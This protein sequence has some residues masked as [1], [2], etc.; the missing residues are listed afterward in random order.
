MLLKDVDRL[1]KLVSGVRELA[2]I[3]TQLSTGE[4]PV[5]NLSEML[6]VLVTGRGL[7]VSTRLKLQLPAAPILVLGSSDRLWQ[8]FENLIDN[9]AGFSPSG[10]VVEIGAAVQSGECVVTVADRGPGIPEAHLARVFD[11]FFSYRPGGDRR[12]HMGLGLAIAQA[13]VS[14]YGGAIAVRNRVGGGSEFEVR[15]PLADA[16]RPS[17]KAIEG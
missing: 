2:S 17:A 3:D 4:R 1:E 12:E 10:Q 15:L 11:R 14:G 5:I 7:V 16:R 13:V 9:A 6:K 8:V